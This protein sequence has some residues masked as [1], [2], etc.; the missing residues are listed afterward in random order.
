MAIPTADHCLY[1]LYAYN[2]I[3]KRFG[4]ELSAGERLLLVDLYEERNIC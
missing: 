3:L 1:A 4:K 2:I